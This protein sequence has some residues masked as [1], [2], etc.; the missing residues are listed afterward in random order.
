[1]K[2]NSEIRIKCTTEEHNQVKEKASAVG[3][4]IKKFILYI[5]KN[6]KIKILVE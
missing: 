2:E 1:M 3:M 6:S 5:V 4:S